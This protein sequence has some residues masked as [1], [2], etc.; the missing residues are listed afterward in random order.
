MYLDPPTCLDILHLPNVIQ[1]MK[2]A[3]HRQNV[4][5]CEIVFRV[6]QVRTFLLGAI[7]MPLK[8]SFEKD[9]P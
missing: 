8:S 6:Q 4:C 5:N 3:S 9:K 2:Y 1:H 7:K